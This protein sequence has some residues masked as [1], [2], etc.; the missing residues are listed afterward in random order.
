MPLESFPFFWSVNWKENNKM[1]HDRN[2]WVASSKKNINSRHFTTWWRYEI[3]T[4]FIFIACLFILFYRF[5]FIIMHLSYA[6]VIGIRNNYLSPDLHFEQVAVLKNQLTLFKTQWCNIRVPLER[7]TFCLIARRGCDS[8][9]TWT[10]QS[11]LEN[12]VINWLSL[13]SLA[14]PG[15]QSCWRSHLADYSGNPFSARQ[16]R[17]R[18]NKS[19]GRG[20]KE[21]VVI[22]TPTLT[23]SDAFLPL[24]CPQK[25]GRGV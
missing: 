24:D 13:C 16:T 19:Q 8:R 25:K 14:K 6:S 10:T 7:V 11:A 12:K 3:T 21:G 23:T 5:K 1:T 22:R 9:F 4:L 18:S 20:R 17:K 15:G 2:L